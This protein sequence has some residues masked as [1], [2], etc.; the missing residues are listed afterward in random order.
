MTK[1]TTDFNPYEDPFTRRL[2]K[3]KARQLVGKYGFTE[4]DKEDIEQDIYLHVLQRWSSYD[5]DEGHHHKFI[6]AV[7][8]RY[9]VNFLRDRCA[10][11]R[12][13]GE[14]KSLEMPLHAA[15]EEKSIGESLTDSVADTRLCRE[16]R[17][18]VELID[19]RLD[20]QIVL[21]ELPPRWREVLE[22]R[23]SLTVSEISDQLEIPRTT[24]NSWIRQ[25]RERFAEAGLD[26][27]LDL[28]SSDRS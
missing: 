3:R 27:Y 9:I 23:K 26:K 4:F 10:T 25:V 28:S 18:E 14:H 6:T 21:D 12:Y 11:K 16:R 1:T 15:R 20:M 13:E 5:R 19:L 24:I 2:A 8:E 22:L 7:I 17:S